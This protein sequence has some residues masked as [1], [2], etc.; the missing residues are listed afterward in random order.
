M[1]DNILIPFIYLLI[2]RFKNET[3]L[4]SDSCFERPERMCSFLVYISVFGRSVKVLDEQ[5]E[6][7]GADR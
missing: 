4:V 6:K 7:H 5:S 3:L 1:K 2:K